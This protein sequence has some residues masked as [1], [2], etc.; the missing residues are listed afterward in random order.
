MFIQSKGIE[1]K[2]SAAQRDMLISF[3][4]SRGINALIAL[5]S[6]TKNEYILLSILCEHW[7]FPSTEKQLKDSISLPSFE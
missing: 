6:N 7:N 2:L 3:I 5:V 1:N 4:V